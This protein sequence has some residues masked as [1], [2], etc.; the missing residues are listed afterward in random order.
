MSVQATRPAAMFC[1]RVHCNAQQSAAIRTCLYSTPHTTTLPCTRKP[2]VPLP[3]H[4]LPHRKMAI[5][6]PNVMAATTTTIASLS[7]TMLKYTT[8]KARSCSATR[9]LVLIFWL[10]GLSI[11]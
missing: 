8:P 3:A 10:S 9:T 4:C 7:S 1:W 5:R 11:Q 6:Y 2:S